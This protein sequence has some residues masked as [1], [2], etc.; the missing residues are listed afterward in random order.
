VEATAVCPEGRISPN[1]LGLWND[2]QAESF[3]LLVEQCHHYGAK[4]A[5]QIAHAGRKGFDK[6]RLAAPSPL[7][8]SE[9]YGIPNELDAQSVQSTADSFRAAALRAVQAGFDMIE[10][11]AAHGYLI[12]EFLS[13]ITNQRADE[14]GGSLVNRARF[15]KLILESIRSAIPAGFPLA[16]RVSASDYE[17]GGIEIGDMVSII[18]HIKEYVDLVHVSSGGLTEKPVKAY[19]GYQVEFSR[20]IREQCGTPT[21]AV[22]LIDTPALAEEILGNGRADL[23]ALGRV[24]L[25]DP[26]WVINAAHKYQEE[27]F[28]PAFYE[29]GFETV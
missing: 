18:N 19:P 4:V 28:I 29:R 5:V 11:H 8:F 6:P 12:H 25:R 23:V 21:I 2:D 13:P 16:V 3:K 20:I 7:A 17:K 9:R 14:F 26:Y 22:G 27:R 24:L 1:D 15:L 10:V